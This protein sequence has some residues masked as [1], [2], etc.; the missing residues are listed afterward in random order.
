MGD[1][2]N[3]PNGLTSFGVPLVGSLGIQI[4]SR[5][6]S[7]LGA[8][9]LFVDATYG[10]NG[11]SGLTPGDPLATITRALALAKAGSVIFVFSGSYVENIVVTLDYVQIIGVQVAGYARPDVVPVTGVALRV[12]TGHGF[13]ASHMRFASNDNSDSVIQNTS[14]FLY[15]DCVFDGNGSQSSKANLRLVGGPAGTASEGKVLNSYIRGGGSS[16]IIMQHRLAVDG[17]EGTTDNEIA[18]CRFVDNVV[19]DL[20]SA[21]NT[22]GGGTGIYI[23]LS[24]H[25][26]Q[27]MTS[28]A[29]YKYIDFHAGAAG[30]L[31]SNS[32][33]IAH[34]YFADEALTGGSGNQI[35]L[36][37]QAKVH[38]AANYDDI[39]VVNGTTFNN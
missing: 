25:D 31:T 13:T 8:P 35:D 17:G 1:L 19:S 4:P 38:F 12:T 21:V 26:N 2:T 23:N 9:V 6:G 5:A 18:G 15:D 3:F 10:S 20:L 16:G 28:G 27:F 32:A 22:N 14:G 37:G 30:D 29:S 33:L 7:D 34:N 11:N 24:V 39:A 36:A